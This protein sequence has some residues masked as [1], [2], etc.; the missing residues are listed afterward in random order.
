MPTPPGET[1][2][3]LISGGAG[4]IGSHLCD[5]LL[6]RGDTVTVIDNLS[7]GRREN[8]PTRHDRLRFIE[9]D[10]GAALGA[11]GAGERFDAIYHLAAA[12]GVELVVRDPIRT[13]E[14]NVELT[15]AVLRFARER[16]RP[17]CPGGIPTLVASTSEVY[18]KGAKSPFHEEDDVVYGPTSKARW[19]YAYSKAIDEHL[20]LAYHRQHAFPGVIAR[21][22]N[23]VGPRQVGTYGM[24]VPRFVEAALAGRDLEVYGDGRQSRCFCHVA[25]VVSVLPRL[26]ETPGCTGRVFNIGSDRSVTIRELAE[27]V[28]GLLGSKSA[29][30]SKAYDEAYADGFEDL[31]ERRPDISR[32]NGA[33]GFTPS[34]DLERIILDVAEDVR[35][36]GEGAV[37]GGPRRGEGTAAC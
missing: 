30:R 14:T 12:V 29:I 19:S 6:S 34:I 8:L 3:I 2:H 37:P 11:L 28:V 16:A 21:F 22:F 9:A 36:R 26:L 10:L 4:F 32:I 5:L 27:L 31:R 7:T 35:S 13:I 33:V 20:V 24:V 23:T 17:D 1:R 25:D 18:G 15:S